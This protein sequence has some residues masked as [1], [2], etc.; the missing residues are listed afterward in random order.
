MGTISQNWVKIPDFPQVRETFARPHPTSQ[1]PKPGLEANLASDIGL[2]WV[3]HYLLRV[4]GSLVRPTD[5][6]RKGEGEGEGEMTRDRESG[7][8]EI[9]R[10]GEVSNGLARE[11]IVQPTLQGLLRRE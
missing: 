7:S 2:A 8:G 11:G 9:F 1:A 4:H 10:W 3:M 5:T 6:G